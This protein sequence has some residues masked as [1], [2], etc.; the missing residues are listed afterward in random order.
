MA[1]PPATSAR[2][3]VDWVPA[4]AAASWAVITWWSTAVLGTMPK[5]SGSRVTVSMHGAVDAPALD[6]AALGLGA[7][8][9]ALTDGVG[10]G[11]G[12]GAS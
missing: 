3:R 6:G 11:H 5:I 7:L 8:A 2:V 1:P 4:R 10:A 9:A 12:G